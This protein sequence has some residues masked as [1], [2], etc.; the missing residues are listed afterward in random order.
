VSVEV[1]NQGGQGHN[2][3]VDA[4]NLSTG[5]VEPGGVVNRDL[6][7]PRTQPPNTW[8]RSTRACAARTSRA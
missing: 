4:L 3:T 8:A 2:F 5:T 1:R 6:H 7:G